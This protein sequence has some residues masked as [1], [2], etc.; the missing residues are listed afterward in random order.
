MLRGGGLERLLCWRLV[1]S[2]KTVE[3]GNSHCA[4]VAR[5]LP[6][7][8]EITGSIPGFTQCVKDPALPRAVVYVIDEALIC[9]LLWLWPATVLALIQPLAWQFPYATGVALKKKMPSAELESRHRWPPG[10]HGC[11]C[12]GRGVGKGTKRILCVICPPGQ[13]TAMLAEGARFCMSPHSRPVR[14]AFLVPFC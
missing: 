12:C 4:S 7:T 13:A 5:N 9:K 10:P 14:S 6:G 8:H 11:A 3:T 1:F 2:C